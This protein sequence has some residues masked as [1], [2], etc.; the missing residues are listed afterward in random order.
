[1]VSKTQRPNWE[2]VAVD[3]EMTMA[4]ISAPPSSPLSAGV[5]DA[6]TCAPGYGLCFCREHPPH[7]YIHTLPSLGQFSL[8]GPVSEKPPTSVSN[9]HHSPLSWS[10]LSPTAQ[11]RNVKAQRGLTVSQIKLSSSSKLP[12]SESIVFFPFVIFILLSI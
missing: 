10:Y 11:I 5:K 2:V 3:T 6:P 1:M 9:Y 8:K 4:K 12:N 7:V